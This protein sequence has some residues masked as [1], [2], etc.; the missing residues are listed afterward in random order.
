MK[1]TL[2][3][4]LFGNRPMKL[5]IVVCAE[6]LMHMPDIYQF[7]RDKNIDSKMTSNFHQVRITMTGVR[8]EKH[9]HS[10]QQFIE[11]NGWRNKNHDLFG[12]EM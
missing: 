7:I 1:A 9:L 4:D 12:E 3:S 11:E 5:V 8:L 2:T 6:A 10:V